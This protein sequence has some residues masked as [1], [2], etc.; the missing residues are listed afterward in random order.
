MVLKK[1]FGRQK[2]K[3]KTVITAIQDK[4][5]GDQRNEFLGSMPVLVVITSV[6]AILFL[7]VFLL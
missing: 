4:I 3:D 7:Y 5:G 6:K 1:E 2:M